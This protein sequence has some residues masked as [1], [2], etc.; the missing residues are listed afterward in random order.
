MKLKGSH[1]SALQIHKLNHTEYAI[2]TDSAT[3]WKF[4]EFIYIKGMAK[5][6]K[7]VLEVLT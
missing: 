3:P 7:M 5:V 4:V 2:G 6:P 1:S